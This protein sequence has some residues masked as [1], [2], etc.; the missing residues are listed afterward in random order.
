ME[1]FISYQNK[2]YEIVN[3]FVTFLESN[4]RKCWIA[5]RDVV[6]SYASDI[7]HA[8]SK[9]S[10]FLVFIDSNTLESTHVLNEIEQAY[11][12]FCA[13]QC[14]IIP[15]YLE[16]VTL[17]AD[18]DYYLHRIQH[19][20]AFNNEFEAFQELLKKINLLID[21]KGENNDSHVDKEVIH[22][23]YEKKKDILSSDE[24]DE[25]RLAN[26]YY[27]VD[28]RYEKKRLKTEGEFLLPFTKEVTKNLI[29]EKEHLNAL[30]TCCMYAPAIMNKYDLSKFDKVVGLCYNELATLEA[31]YDYKTDKCKFFTQDVEDEDFEDK[32]IAYK[33]EMGIE[34][35]DYIDITMGFLDWKNPFKVLKIL[36]RHMNEGCRIYVQDI[37]DSVLMAY[38]DPNQ[39]F[40]TF[41]KFYVLD[42]IAGY[43]KSGRKIFGYFKKIK[44][45]EIK[46]VHSGIDITDIDDEQKEKLFFSYFG[47]IPNDFRIS[48]NKDP[49]KVE[50]KEVIEW[51]DTYYDDLE[52]AFMADDFFYNSG[53]FIF[54]I[55]M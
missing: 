47:F 50:Y 27:D 37:D 54:A 15:V 30:I 51:C 45:K 17:T 38:P 55:K 35:F 32:L 23:A 19:I 22:N 9:C 14:S 52:E 44:A 3:R 26:R 25:V 40:K 5:P 18:L 21:K 16:D 36:K 46:L 2:S 7:V 34:K 11:K 13:H 48:Y 41:K 33:K 42:P 29:G 43:R 49:S 24:S 1:V 10:I 31:N 4:G 8:I 39:L 53:Y 6:I 20:N 28:D 12:Y